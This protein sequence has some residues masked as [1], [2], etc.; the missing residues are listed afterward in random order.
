MSVPSNFYNNGNEEINANTNSNKEHESSISWHFLTEQQLAEMVGFQD[1][2]DSRLP[3][4]PDGDENY[5]TEYANAESNLQGN[6][7]SQNELFEDPVASKTEP[8]F[9]NNPFSKIGLVGTALFV[10][11]ISAGA[12]L[13][14]VITSKSSR[15]VVTENSSPSPTPSPTPT[16][17][18][19]EEVGNLK[20]QVALA[21]QEEQLKAVEKVNRPKTNV[22][23]VET[24][25]KEVAT[26]KTTTANTPKTSTV[27][28]PRYSGYSASPRRISPVRNVTVAQRSM[29]AR[30][31]TTT[32]VSRAEA[33]KVQPTAAKQLAVKVQPKK[34]VRTT[35]NFD[36]VAEWQAMSKLGSYGINEV[37]SNNSQTQT[38]VA[39]GQETNLVKTTPT[40]VMPRATKVV[41]SQPS[42]VVPFPS[43]PETDNVAPN[44]SAM[45]ASGSAIPSSSLEVPFPTKPTAPLFPVNSDLAIASTE[46]NQIDQN[47][48]AVNSVEEQ[49]ILSNIPSQFSN[50]SYTNFQK[51]LARTNEQEFK[52]FDEQMNLAEE[53]TFLTSTQSRRLMVGSKATG[54]LISPAIWFGKE[55]NADTEQFVVQLTQPLTDSDGSISVPSGSEIVATIE[56]VSA[57]GVAVVKVSRLIMDGQEYILPEGAIT[58]RGNNGQALM[59]S[60]SGNKNSEIVSRDATTFV[61]GSLSKVGEV[62]N[63]PN[64]ETSTSSSGVGINQ[65]TISRSGNRNILGAILEG[66]FEPLNQEILRRNRQ[67]TEQAMSRPDTWYIPANQSVQLVITRSFEL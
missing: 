24:P 60:K 25:S 35:N 42:S 66:G 64:M 36:P 11:F 49:N 3:V 14:S 31:R 34:S 13:S 56:R 47:S 43:E 19:N 8:S 38:V 22:A 67:A 23:K 44:S 15:P 6:V 5:T 59:A 61:L 28:P 4:Y 10:V 18:P 53:Q 55:G 21:K 48:L 33:P 9:S 57:S 7:I 52:E 29:P 45:L 27:P 30:L 62:L 12:F 54:K 39:Q 51:T 65:T 40:L 37:Q 46:E 50:S 20:T 2:D 17:E 63:R 26:T 32:T 16:L 41:S 1:V 58:L